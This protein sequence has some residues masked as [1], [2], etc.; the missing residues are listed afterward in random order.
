[1]FKASLL[2]V[3]TCAFF[4]E[5]LTEDTR[6]PL[7]GILMQEGH[8]G[9]S[10]L[11]PGPSENYVYAA[12]SYID[13]VSHTGATPVLLPFDM[14]S[15]KMRKMLEKLNGVLLPG[16]GSELK[17]ENQTSTAYQIVSE[18]ILKYAEER[19][20][21]D[22]VIFPVFA[23]CLG[24]ES[25]MMRYGGNAILTNGFKDSLIDHPVVINE[26]AF[27]SSK[28]F[29]K[30]NQERLRKVF[31]N[32]Y[33]YFSHDLGIRYDTLRMPEFQRIY[34]EV[35]M[36]G[37]SKTGVHHDGT[38]FVSTI[39]HK[40]YP[41]Y[42]VQYHPEKML[43][44]RQHPYGFMDRSSDSL[45]LSHDMAATFVDVARETAKHYTDIPD[46]MKPHIASYWTPINTAYSHFEKM[47]ILPRYYSLVQPSTPEKK[48]EPVDRLYI[49]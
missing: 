48:T 13:W 42:A 15:K 45:S 36:I 47:Y 44:E 33:M 32:G 20:D 29:A 43:F 17:Y 25:V 12:A 40:R 49:E 31:N 27:Q 7:I 30:L 6:I 28:F 37:Y 24:F 38:Q 5:V 26:T 14:P 21:K 4:L 16:G 18:E 46:W 8:S 34:K 39:E 19:F 10:G 2:A 9:I 1:M 3:A 35:L 11:L 41:I 23:I 22:N